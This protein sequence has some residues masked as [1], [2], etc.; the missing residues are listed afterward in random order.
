MDELRPDVTRWYS[1]GMVRK[2]LSWFFQTLHGYDGPVYW[3]SQ[4]QLYIDFQLSTGFRGPAKI[5][6]WIDADD[7]QYF[8]LADHPFRTRVR[9][10]NKVLRETFRKCN[11]PVTHRFGLPQSNVLGLHLS[12]LALPWPMGRIEL[13]DKWILS[14]LPDGV[15]RMSTALDHLPLAKRSHEF[16]TVFISTVQ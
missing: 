13:V 15:R 14:F 12:T 2:I 4:A 10:F 6:G 1:L 8:S 11:Q 3:I 9:W 16:D 5:N 7:L